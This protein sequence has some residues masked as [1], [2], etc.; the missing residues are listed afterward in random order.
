[1]TRTSRD[2]HD[3][4]T[5]LLRERS[6]R[7]SRHLPKALAGE[8]EAIHQ[9]RVAARR[10]RVVLP[11]LAHKPGGRRAR[12][13]LKILRELART[14]GLSR[15][16]DVGLELFDARLREITPSPDQKSLRRAL[17]GAR[18]R[19]RQR[20]AEGLLDLEIARLRRHLRAIQGRGA[21]PEFTVLVRLREAAYAEF[22]GILED[23]E[24]LGAS[25]DAE[26]LHALRTRCR[27][28]RYI[29]EVRDT[30]RGQESGAPPVLRELQETLGQLH[31]AHVLA[32][33]LQHAAERA[34]THGRQ[35]LATAARRERN[36]FLEQAR[37]LHGAF[38]ASKPRE[39]LGRAL[40][41][42][43]PQRAR[44]RG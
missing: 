33:W 12:Q 15:D 21:E 3:T 8:A 38:L 10:L 6:R 18:N 4:A 43:L 32:A 13:A 17:V 35:A 24:R 16:L 5:D 41:S 40:A 37:G 14:G 28:L 7:V 11:L 22:A 34:A 27:R 20:M 30:V 26:A 1:M 23:L 9:M 2:P 25:F 44:A 42:M 36:H 31:D 19:G 29:A 39:I